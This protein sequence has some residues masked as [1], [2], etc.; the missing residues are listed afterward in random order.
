[1]ADRPQDSVARAMTDDGAFRTITARTTETVRRAVELQEATGDGARLLADVITGVILVRETMA[2]NQRVQGIL[3]GAGGKGRIIADS[4]PNGTSRGLF[5]LPDGVDRMTL[6]EGALLQ[7]MRTLPR[8]DL[9]RGVVEAPAEGGISG[10]L[11]N[12]MQSSEQVLSAVSVGALFDGDTVVEAGGYVVQLLP[13][14]SEAALMIM[15][16]RLQDFPPITQL[17]AGAEADPKTLTGELLYR[18][19]HTLLDESPLAFGCNC[20]ELRLLGSLSTL[21]RADIEHLMEQEGP[22]EIQCDYCGSEYAIS[23]ERL[24]GLL[25]PA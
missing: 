22:L 5:R 21:G 20:S 6:G 19:E 12:Y 8:G 17:L 2:P 10:A 1:M 13:E 14:L 7:M 4:H 9:Q 18:M 25:D 15:T 3:Q 23:P 16:A 24:R 11:M